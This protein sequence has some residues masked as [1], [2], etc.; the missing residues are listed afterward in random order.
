MEKINEKEEKN[1]NKELLK[2]NWLTRIV[3]L[4][5]VAGIYCNYHNLIIFQDN[6]GIF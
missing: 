6:L 4:R 1:E 5:A 3:Y 2:T